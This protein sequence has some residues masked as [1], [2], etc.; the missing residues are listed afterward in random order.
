MN[1]NE[2]QFWMMIASII[3][4]V[5]FVVMAIALIAIALVV[6][7]VIGTVNRLEQQVEPLIAKVNAVSVQSKEISVH[8]TEV[9]ANLST[10]TKYLA[11]STELVKEEVV[12][13]RQLV[14][15]T[16]LVAR[17]KVQMVSQTIDRTHDQVTDT[18]EFVQ[19]KIVVPAREIAAIMA[20]VKKGLEVLFAPAPKRIDRV[21]VEDEMFIG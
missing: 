5:C 11:E 6:R 9:S 7:R 1:L 3:I 8:L 14:S 15:S 17:D 4:A 20:G 19:Q 12:E 21:Y 2:P 18:T 10:A 16:A 13:L